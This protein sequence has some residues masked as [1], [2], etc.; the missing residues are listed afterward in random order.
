MSP[1]NIA[2][3]AVAVLGVLLA[4]RFY[5]ELRRWARLCQG[6]RIAVAYKRRIKLQ[7]PLTD[8]LVWAGQLTRDERSNGRVVYLMGGTSVAIMAPIKP[9]SKLAPLRRRVRRTKSREGAP[10]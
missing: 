1:L 4:G 6:A 5:L 7:A 3:I 8:F 10:V 9:P 2:L